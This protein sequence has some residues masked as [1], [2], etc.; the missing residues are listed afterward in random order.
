MK[1]I[2]CSSLFSLSLSRLGYPEKHPDSETYEDD[3]K[4]L[5]FKIDCG[6]NLIITQMFYD[7]QVFLKFVKDCRDMGMSTD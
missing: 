2:C 3:L 4:N 1:I 6:A 7:V 5:K